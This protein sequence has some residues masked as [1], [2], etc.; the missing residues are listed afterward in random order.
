MDHRGASVKSQMKRA[1]RLGSGLVL[2]LGE[3]EQERGVVALRDMATSE[4]EEVPLAEVLARALS[5][6]GPSGGG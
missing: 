5:R 3:A 1:H 4:Q 6:L 2:L